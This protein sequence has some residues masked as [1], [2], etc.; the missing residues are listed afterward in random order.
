MVDS[1]ITSEVDNSILVLVIVPAMCA[2]P[3][4]GELFF[5]VLQ[6]CCCLSRL[7]LR[8]CFRCLFPLGDL[9]GCG[10]LA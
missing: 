8:S 6:D 4:V 7:C 1:E 9:P 3:Q 5:Q 10:E 2:V